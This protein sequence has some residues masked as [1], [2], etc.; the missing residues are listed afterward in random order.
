MKA[1]LEFNLPDDQDEHELAIN[2][3]KYYSVLWELDQ[4]LRNKTKYA[5]DDVS[6]ED[7]EAIQMVR[8]ELWKLMEEN[9]L[10]LDK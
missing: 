1:I 8:D 5:S 10:D 7:I 4:Y 9:N 2:A 6:S 3:R